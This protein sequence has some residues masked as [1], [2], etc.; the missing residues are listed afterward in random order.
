MALAAG[1]W[2]GRR[3]HR[4]KVGE[5]FATTARHLPLLNFVVVTGVGVLSLIAAAWLGLGIGRMLPTL[6]TA[7]TLGVAGVLLVFFSTIGPPDW[8]AAAISPVHGST[9]FHDYQTIDN[10]SAVRSRSG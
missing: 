9:P 3:E 10:R 4:A 7:P 8:V 6:V 5:L 1:A 2:Q